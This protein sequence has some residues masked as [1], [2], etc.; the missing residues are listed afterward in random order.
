MKRRTI[1]ISA[2]FYSVLVIIIL[3]LAK[4]IFNTI[5]VEGISMNPTYTEGDKLLIQ[6]K[7]KDIKRNDVIIYETKSDEYITYIIKRVIGIPGDTIYID[8]NNTVYV[9]DKPFDDTYGY[10]DDNEGY[11]TNITYTLSDN[12]YFT[13]GDNRNHSIDARA[14][15]N[16]SKDRIIGTVLFRYKKNK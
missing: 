5:E 8:D 13:L 4:N 2:T 1:V 3:S 15:G 9:N 12:E 6:T 11:E 14:T 16:I 10:Y 7:F